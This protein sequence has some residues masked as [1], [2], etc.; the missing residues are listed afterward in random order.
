MKNLLLTLSL[1][2]VLIS[3]K[4]DKTKKVETQHAKPVAAIKNDGTFKVVESQ[5]L[6]KGYKPTGSHNG[7]ID[8]KEGAL[9]VKENQLVG[10]KF[11]ID[12][13]TIKDLDIP[14]TDPYN[15]KLIDHLK[16]PEFFDV[17][18]YPTATFEITAVRPQA[19]NY[20]IEGNLTLKG[21]TKNITFPAMVL[22]GKDEITFYS[23]AIKIDR[24][25][26]GIIHKSKKFFDNLKDKFI[27]DLFD[28]SFKIK[29][30]K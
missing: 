13:T 3:C 1:I 20:L 26:F 18:K 14:E 21:I 10:G 9:A 23:D 2:V 11:V 29:A 25:D 24:T 17:A 8:L 5:I 7:S 22:N 15:K 28:V 27:N 6:W 4:E 16:S 30:K 12:M 19:E